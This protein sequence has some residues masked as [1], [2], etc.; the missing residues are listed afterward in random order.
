VSL[1]TAQ[2]STVLDSK[3]TGTPA[4]LDLG[5]ATVTAQQLTLISSG[6]PARGDRPGDGQQRGAD[7]R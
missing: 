5:A 1:S 7:A 4:L 6:P 2:P 3:L